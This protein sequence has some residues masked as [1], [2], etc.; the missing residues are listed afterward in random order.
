ME[1]LHAS[2]AYLVYMVTILEQ[3][4]YFETNKVNGVELEHEYS[5]VLLYVGSMM[6]TSCSLA[7]VVS[8]CVA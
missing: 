8:M 6:L 4:L 5:G 2:I 7:A 3:R 1:Y